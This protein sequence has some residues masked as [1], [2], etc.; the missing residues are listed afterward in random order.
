MLY[1]YLKFLIIFPIMSFIKMMHLHPQ[2]IKVI[3]KLYSQ[4]SSTF[5]VKNV[6]FCQMQLQRICNSTIRCSNLKNF[7]DPRESTA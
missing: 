4:T 7:G 6:I 2:F 5:F 3:T 1:L